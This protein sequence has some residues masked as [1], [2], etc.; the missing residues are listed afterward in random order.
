MGKA[1]LILCQSQ[2]Q[3][4]LYV[5]GVVALMWS[6]NQRE[7]VEIFQL[8]VELLYLPNATNLEAQYNTNCQLIVPYMPG[9]LQSYADIPI[10]V[11]PVKECFSVPFC[12][13]DHKFILGKVESME[14]YLYHALI[15]QDL[16]EK[17]DLASFCHSF[18]FQAMGR[19]LASNISEKL[20][21]DDIDDE[22]IHLLHE[23]QKWMPQSELVDFCL[24]LSL[25][26]KGEYQ[27][28]LNKALPI[29]ERRRMSVVIL[30]MLCRI[31]EKLH[32]Y[33]EAA[34][35]Y[36]L[37]ISYCLNSKA[38]VE[39]KPNQEVT[40]IMDLSYPQFSN[41]LTTAI[42]APIYKKINL[43]KKNLLDK[44]EIY[45][46]TYL[47]ND[48]I[49]GDRFWVGFYNGGH[50]FDALSRLGE[51]IFAQGDGGIISIRT[52][53]VYDLMKAE[54]GKSV[55]VD[56]YENDV[57]IP[58]AG[59]EK[60]QAIEF[61]N[62][63]NEKINFFLPKEEFSFF[64]LSEKTKI[65]SAGRMAFGQP[66]VLKHSPKRKKLVLNILV[67]AMSW[68]HIKKENYRSIPHIMQFFQKGIIFDNNY[69]VS[70]YTYPSLATIETGI[71][72]QNNQMIG[73]TIY[74]HLNKKY[75]TLS[76]QMKRLGY[77]CTTVMGDTTG[78]Y[79]G[80]SRGQDRIIANH[81]HLDSN[82]AMERL[83]DHLEA[84]SECDNFIFCHLTDTHPFYK[85][86]SQVRL[87]TQT[88]LSL[89]DRTRYQENV[90]SVNMAKLLLH[91]YDNDY[92]LRRLD[93][94]LA[95]LF[96]YI[97][98]HY[99]EDE[100][101]IN[102]YSDH[103]VSIY[104][105]TVYYLSEEQNCAAL[106]MRGGGIP[107][108]GRV[109]DITNTADIYP[110]IGKQVGFSV[111]DYVDGVIPKC[112]G[113]KGRK[114]TISHSIFQD[115]TYKLCIR[116]EQYE[117]RFET[118]KIINND[119][120]IDASSFKYRLLLRKD[121]TEV[122]DTVLIDYFIKLAFDYIKSFNVPSL[123]ENYRIILKE[124]ND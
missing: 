107:S 110:I 47:F 4:D 11:F 112:L 18:I 116:D 119:T 76:E 91:T 74:E 109:D 48:K 34:F 121:E 50:L 40:K 33:N 73:A 65:S 80:I 10:M 56:V 99:N 94:I 106:M 86:G 16:C 95:N 14:Y 83:F 111:P 72:P 97:I 37:Y 84:F 64:R 6:Y 55:I 118:L 81:T 23:Y 35:Y 88:K 38:K 115:K 3:E 51:S 24:V 29:F 60:H 100:Y 17:E 120:T 2:F 58:L 67:D 52:D 1:L 26:K 15:M 41:V 42:H 32:D 70:E 104:S 28:A 98:E 31:Y 69:S 61:C 90:T 7:D 9:T 57:V 36:G 93:S 44:A 85:G 68:G 108:L 87:P 54:E 39:F 102:M 59:T 117:F 92:R 13:K 113:G 96:E 20:T 12:K 49:K 43:H 53:L 82:V 78:V 45:H 89:T 77:Y 79:N 75:I 22:F 19:V 8:L 101:I 105:D 124:L 62:S 25:Y 46:G 66:I 5:E 30:L 63:S 21:Q 122:Y 114:F 123:D 103:G 71:Y 27:E